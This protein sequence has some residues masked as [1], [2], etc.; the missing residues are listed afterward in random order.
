M[1]DPQ[2]PNFY[3][4]N[5]K[6]DP[7]FSGI[8]RSFKSNSYIKLKVNVY[9]TSPNLFNAKPTNSTLLFSKPGNRPI[10]RALGL[11]QIEKLNK[12]KSS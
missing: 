11:G 6:K 5:L 7:L 8:F 4:A 3:Y 10:F 12:T 1:Q 9:G 2:I